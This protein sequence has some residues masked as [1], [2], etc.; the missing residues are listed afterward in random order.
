VPELED[1]VPQIVTPEFAA[2]LTSPD[3]GYQGAI[4]AGEIWD[5]R[6]AWPHPE[7]LRSARMCYEAF[8][9]GDLAAAKE[10]LRV[11]C[12]IVA[13]PFVAAEETPRFA[14][15]PPSPAEAAEPPYFR[16]RNSDAFVMGIFLAMGF[17]LVSLM[18]WLFA[19]VFL[20]GC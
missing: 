18:I 9:A 14:V 5:V 13:S 19:V 8:A 4:S 10:Q 17:S 7:A 16:M 1:P 3:S 2:W 11:A 15:A 20:K 12:M 6:E